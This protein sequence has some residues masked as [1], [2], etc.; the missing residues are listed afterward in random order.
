VPE[1]QDKVQSNPMCIYHDRAADFFAQYEIV[2]AE[3]VH[4]R[5]LP[6]LDTLPSSQALDIGAG[7]GRDARFLASLGFRVTAVEPADALR[8]QAITYWQQLPAPR[9]EIHWLADQLPELPKVQALK[10]RFDL[11]LLSAV[12]MHL[13]AVEREYT[14]PILCSLLA[15]NGLLVI[16][17]RHGDFSDG[18]NSY[19]VHS[20]EILRRINQLHLPLAPMLVTDLEPDTLGRS[21]VL[22]Q[23]VV[24]KKG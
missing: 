14:L 4:Q 11:V 15:P 2:S 7:S 5:W 20:D 10:Q 16:T 9:P 21:D 6:L 24:L 22:W 18:R 8:E 19:P 1:N 23:T 17:L 12:W 13:T 3:Q